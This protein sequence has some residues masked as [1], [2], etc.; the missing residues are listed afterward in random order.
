VLQVNPVLIQEQNLTIECRAKKFKLP[1]VPGLLE[2]ISFAVI[3]IEKLKI[4]LI[5]FEA[6]EEQ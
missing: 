3:V 5:S 4:R 2:K 6:P 1:K